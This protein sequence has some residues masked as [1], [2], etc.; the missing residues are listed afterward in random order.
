MGSDDPLT[1]AIY[2]GIAIFLGKLYRDDYRALTRGRPNPRA[3]P[4]ATPCAR[5]SIVIG[6]IGAGVILA[7]ETGGELALGVAAEQSDVTALFLGAM[8]AAGLIE[9]TVFRGY[10]VVEGRGR[11]ALIGSCIGFSALFA[12]IHPFLWTYSVPEGVAAWRFWEASFGFDLS[13][14]ALFSA[15]FAFANSLWFYAARFGPWNPRRSI[16]PAFAAHAGSNLGVFAVKLAQ[17]H[18]TGWW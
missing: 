11:A 16:F 2:V 3:L 14:K 13:P 18:V 10:L 7:A 12:L 17:G 1:I 8:L 5:A 15:G 9:E 6:L 4:G